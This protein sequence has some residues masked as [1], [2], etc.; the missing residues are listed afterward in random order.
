M[1]PGLPSKVSAR[2][3]LEKCLDTATLSGCARSMQSGAAGGIHQTSL[4]RFHSFL[5]RLKSPVC[6]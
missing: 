4:E 3:Y 5:D 2:S 1:S 6:A